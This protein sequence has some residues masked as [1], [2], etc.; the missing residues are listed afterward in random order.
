MLSCLTIDFCSMCDQ[1]I[2]SAIDRLAEF[3]STMLCSFDS[4]VGRAVDLRDC[5]HP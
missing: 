5:G 3:D 2:A 4:S 1:G